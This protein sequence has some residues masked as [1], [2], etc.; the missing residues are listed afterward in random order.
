M[1]KSLPANVIVSFQHVV[2]FDVVPTNIGNAYQSFTGRFFVPETGV[3]VFIWGFMIENVDELSAQLMINSDIW[4]IVRANSGSD[5]L[6]QSTGVVV[7]HVNKGDEVFVKLAYD[8]QGVVHSE[9][10]SRT[11]FAGWKLH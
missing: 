3:Y 9:F 4:G 1:S 11:M 10:Y 7:A 8:R 2:V 6:V 5:V